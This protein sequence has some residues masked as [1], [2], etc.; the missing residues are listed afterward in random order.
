[1]YVIP[2]LGPPHV[3]SLDSTDGYDTKDRP[4]RSTVTVSVG[5]SYTTP[6][7]ANRPTGSHA[8]TDSYLYFE[9]AGSC[10]SEPGRG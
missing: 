2:L 6:S 4:S 8:A 10:S 7:T 9:S 1:M 3:V 5:R